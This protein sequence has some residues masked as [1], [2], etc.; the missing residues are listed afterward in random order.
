MNKSSLKNFFRKISHFNLVLIPTDPYIST[1][2]YKISS[3]RILVLVIIYSLILSVSGFYVIT[4][5]KLNSVFLPESYYQ[6]E[7]NEEIKKLNEKIIFLA[8]EIEKLQ[9]NNNKLKNIFNKQDSISQKVNEKDSLKKKIQGNIFFIVRDFI[10]KFFSRIQNEIIFLKPVEGILSNKFNPSQ[11]HFG[12][13]FSAKENTPIFASANGYIS[14]AGFTPEYGNEIIIVHK[15]DFITK[16]KHCSI[17]I[18]KAGDRVKQGELIAL[19][20]NTGMKSHGSHLHFE[21]WQN[22]KPVNP[23]NY[24]LNF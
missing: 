22:G 23:E 16:Y 5:L 15:S 9:I 21:I 8:D 12:L 1:K 2:S 18:K 6:S 14:F 19:V 13:D 20:G 7:R 11:G 10:D 4:F 3:V 17:L 24:L